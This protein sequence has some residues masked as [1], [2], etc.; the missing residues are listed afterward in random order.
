M[1]EHNITIIAKQKD[2]VA[3]SILCYLTYTKM[4]FLLY[5][6]EKTQIP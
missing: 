4:K 1:K 6:T 2:K 5:L 3:Y